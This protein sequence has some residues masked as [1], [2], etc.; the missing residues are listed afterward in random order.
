MAHRVAS[1]SALRNLHE[2]RHRISRK[3]VELLPRSF[4]PLK[5]LHDCR[6]VAPYGCPLFFRHKFRHFL[7]GSMPAWA[8]QDSVL[9]E[10]L[11]SMIALTRLLHAQESGEESPICAALFAKN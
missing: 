2:D 4:A 8:E 5:S 11:D 10:R 7:A 9:A 3:I 6:G 1:A